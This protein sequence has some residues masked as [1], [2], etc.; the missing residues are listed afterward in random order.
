MGRR[1]QHHLDLRLTYADTES[2]GSQFV[3]N[4]P[5]FLTGLVG[6]AQYPGNGSAPPCPACPRR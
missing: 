4:A 1:Q 6:N 5:N 2:T 3:S